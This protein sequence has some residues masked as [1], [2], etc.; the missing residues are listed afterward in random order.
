MQFQKKEKRGNSSYNYNDESSQ[1][2]LA[3]RVAGGQRSPLRLEK[4]TGESGYGEML[5]LDPNDVNFRRNQAMSPVTEGRQST[6][7]GRSPTNRFG[8][9]VLAAVRSDLNERNDT[10]QVMGSRPLPNLNVTV[11]NKR[12]ER[13]ERSPKT[14]NIG[15]TEKDLEYNIRTLNPRRS[16]KNLN[17]INNTMY[18]TSTNYNEPGNIFLDQPMQSGSF[19]QGQGE[20]STYQASPMAGMSMLQAKPSNDYLNGNSR[21]IQY[22]MNPRDLREP[23]PNLMNKMSPNKNVDDESTSDNKG[24]DTA[25]QLKD[26]KSQMDRNANLVRNEGD[27]MIEQPSR[28]IRN[29]MEKMEDYTKNREIRDTITEGEMKKLVRQMTK[30]YDPRKGNEGRLIST[31]QTIIPGA[32]A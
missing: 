28:Q 32:N 29:D 25:T 26:L 14:I 30:G 16:P 3:G 18:Q 11:E 12:R 19:L 21:E 6:L 23:L 17:Q 13:L 31:S 27:G 24:N 4:D 22:S 10:A 2:P 20:T 9:S 7:Q 1:S 8:Q 15:D 5:Y